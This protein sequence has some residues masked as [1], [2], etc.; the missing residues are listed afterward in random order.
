MTNPR[1]CP[2]CEEIIPVQFGFSFDNKLNLICGN[3]QKIAFP[4]CC[5]A[6]ARSLYHTDKFSQNTQETFSSK[7][8]GLGIVKDVPE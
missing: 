6:E 5:E 4:A 1:I 7:K 3:C 2:H 8:Y